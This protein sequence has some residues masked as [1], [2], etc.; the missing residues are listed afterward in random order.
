M[1]INTLASMTLIFIL[2]ACSS[3]SAPTITPPPPTS[4]TT[5][6]PTN[7]PLP[8]H[9]PSPTLTPSPVPTKTELPT[10]T[11]GPSPTP[12]KATSK[13]TVIVPDLGSG[14]RSIVWSRDGKYLYIGTYDKGVAIYDVVHKKLLSF[15]GNTADVS[16]LAIS[17]DGKFLAVGIAND[18]SVR[19]WALE[20]AQPKYEVTIFPA[21]GDKVFDP[22]V[23]G[24]AFSP[25]GKWVVS[26]GFDGKVIV[27][28]AY[29][30]EMIKKFDVEDSVFEVAFSPDGKSLIAGLNVHEKFDVWNTDTW[31][32]Q[33]TLQGDQA[34]DLAISP[35][36]SKIISA[37]GGI[38]EANL[39]DVKTGTRLFNF[40][41]ETDGFAE[42]VSYDPNG[43]LVAL[44]DGYGYVF[45]LD[46]STGQLLKVFH[47]DGDSSSISALAFNPDGTKVATAG[48]QVIIWDVDTP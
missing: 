9:T 13:N 31:E 48:S 46:T 26:S 32:L 28:D 47:I 29:T 14:A 8:T 44:G 12:I 21:H 11:P 17:P 39:W 15:V 36:G 5:P 23:L 38:H 43:K 40:H 1:K 25:D 4:T 24:L 22:D 41:K 45:F 20:N 3:M 7:T 19:L 6:V 2:A 37:G 18:G 16:S 10:F 35:D 27:W 33:N 34:W 30:G 42:A